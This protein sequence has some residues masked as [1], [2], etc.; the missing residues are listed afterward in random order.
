MQSSFLAHDGLA[1]KPK[2]TT[3]AGDSLR[4]V[5]VKEGSSKPP[6]PIAC[7]VRRSKAVVYAHACNVEARLDINASGDYAG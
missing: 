5:C 3:T 6:L 7:V 1:I 4:T 2:S